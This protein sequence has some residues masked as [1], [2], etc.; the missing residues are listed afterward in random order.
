MEMLSGVLGEF[1][2][3]GMIVLIVVFQQEIR[4]FLL[5]IGSTNFGKRRNFFRQ[6][7]FLGEEN[8]ET[9]TNVNSLVKACYNLGAIKA[10]ALIVI[11]R[12]APLEFIT[13]TGDKMDI[14]INTPIIESIFYKNSTLHDGAMVVEDN[15]IV[16]TRAI[17]PVSDNRNIPL[18]YGLRHRAAVGVT[19]KT[20]ATALVVSEE[21]GKISYIKDGEFVYFE[22]REDLIHKLK[23]DLK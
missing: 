2:D 18:R 5:M 21:T 12:S 19:E 16:A 15:K 4:K 20:D 13:N 14:I 11:K 10:G 1:I 6:L 9:T 22:N 17:L 8:L 7:K 23:K 3:V